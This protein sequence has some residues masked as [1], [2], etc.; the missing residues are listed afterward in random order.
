MMG[1]AQSHSHP[2]GHYSLFQGPHCPYSNR[3][4]SPTMAQSDADAQELWKTD[5]EPRITQI[6]TGNEPLT[7]ATHSAV[8]SAGYDLILK[9]K[10]KGQNNNNNNCK[11]LYAQVQSFFAEYTQRIRGA[12]PSDGSALSAY[13]DAEWDR[14]SRGVGIVDRLLDYLNKHYVNRLRA[15]GQTTVLTVRNLAFHNW[16]K[17]VFEAL[18][19]HLANTDTG[20]ARIETIRQ[21]F[22]SEGELKADAE[23]YP[24]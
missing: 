21:L 13:Y 14:F 16:K 2:F 8:Y 24:F 1:L 18:S 23:G 6:L 10:G 22:A 11:Y 4:T 17:N 5:L 20:K 7:Y 19:S 3:M 9:G 12:A 15:E